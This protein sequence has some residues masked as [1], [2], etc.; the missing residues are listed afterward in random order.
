MRNLKLKIYISLVEEENKS[1]MN[2]L[3]SSSCSYRI[4]DK[5]IRQKY[6]HKEILNL[7]STELDMGH[8]YYK[9][10]L[11][12]KI[13]L[14]LNEDLKEKEIKILS[15][16]KEIIPNVIFSG[17]FLD[18]VFNIYSV[19][20][21]PFKGITEDICHPNSRNSILTT[22]YRNSFSKL[23]DGYWTYTHQGHDFYRETAIRIPNPFDENVLENY[24]KEIGIKFQIIT[25]EIIPLPDVEEDND[26]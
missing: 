9:R 13:Q 6:S 12:S 18:N 23:K 1:G 24:F 3:L 22:I 17:Y 7:I 25:H 2:Q 21:F 4:I 8:Q 26:F 15:D 14:P 5:E 19:Q 16:L 20:S 10:D 11:I